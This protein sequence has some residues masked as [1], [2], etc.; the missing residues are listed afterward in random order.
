MSGT[1]YLVPAP[2]GEASLDATLPLEVRGIANRIGH[3]VVE[4]PKT[5]RAVLK[6]YGPERQIS[7]LI[8]AELNEHTREAEVAALLQPLLDGQD[9]GLMSEAGCPGVADP[10]ANLVRLAHERGIRV[11]PLV[12]PSSI[13]LALMASGAS[14]QRFRF[15]GYLPVE[16][17]ARSSK[18]RELEKDSARMNEAQLFIETPYR[19]DAMLDAALQTC[20]PATRLTIARDL[21][22]AD[23]LVLSLSLAQWQKRARP[24]LK[25]RP[26]LFV[27]Y[28]GK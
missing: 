25:K 16:P 9:V 3:W 1:L 22:T 24:E 7:T 5:A 14:G 10:G 15:H 6:L 20:Q 19:N 2:L 28:A 11:A 8:M 27:L 12:G 23:E 26:A 17:A 13:L 21:T 18:L 4:H